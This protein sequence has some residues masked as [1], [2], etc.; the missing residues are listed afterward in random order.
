VIDQ[1]TRRGDQYIHLG[2]STQQLVLLV[3]NE[4]ILLV[5]KAVMSGGCTNLRVSD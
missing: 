5:G 2:R 1:T 3:R 4:L